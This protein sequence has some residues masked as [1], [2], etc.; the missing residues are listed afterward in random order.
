MGQ[1]HRFWN[2]I[3]QLVASGISNTLQTQKEQSEEAYLRNRGFR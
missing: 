1:H 2:T 3:C